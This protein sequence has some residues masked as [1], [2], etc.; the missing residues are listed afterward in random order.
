MLPVDSTVGCDGVGLHFGLLDE[1]DVEAEL[2]PDRESIFVPEISAHRRR[3][4]ARNGESEA[5][6]LLKAGITL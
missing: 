6:A 2:G 4:L 3:E 1:I 5:D